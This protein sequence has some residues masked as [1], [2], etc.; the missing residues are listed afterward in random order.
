MNPLL[1]PGVGARL[2]RPR[3][4]ALALVAAA[5]FVATWLYRF[6]DPSG[7]FAGLT[8]DHFFYL[9]RGWQMLFGELPVRDFVDHGAPLYYYVAA[10]VQLVFGRGTLTELTFSVTVLA[11]STAIVFLLAVRASGSILLGVAAGVLM[12][13]LDPRFYNYPKILVYALA[14]PALWAF[15]DR[16]GARTRAFVAIVAVVG[17][18]FRHDH[19]VFVGLAFLTML[20]VLRSLPWRERLR[21]G[22]VTLALAAALLSPYLLFIQMN[23]GLASYVEQS[24]AWAE[25]DRDRA[26][27]VWPGFFDNPD[28]VSEETAQTT[29]VSHALAVLAD[30][31]VAWLYYAEIALPFV[32]LL[33]LALSPGAFRPEWPHAPAKLVT[34]AVL[35]VVLNAGFLRHP[36]E[37][38]LA[39]TFVPHAILIAW[40]AMALGRLLLRRGMLRPRLAVPSRAIVVKVLAAAVAVPL[41]A[42]IVLT[43]MRDWHRRLDKAA[44]VEGWDHAIE[45]VGH[46]RTSLGETWPLERWAKPEGTMAL[47][48]YFTAC[49]K[50]TDRVFMEHYLPQVLAL[51]RRGFA[52]GHADLRPGFF[53]SED[54]QR[55]TVERLRRQSVPVALLGPGE[56]LGGFRSSFPIIVAYLDQYYMSAGER[57]ID[58]RDPVQLF[59]RRDGVPTGRYEPLDWPCFS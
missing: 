35:A 53:T 52:G 41:L 14:I 18:L 51:S 25:R 20:L 2:V 29:G 27:V 24:A 22:V 26:E 9:V 23:G 8:D 56:D 48:F 32:A 55:L 43:S 45:R 15:A 31:W 49:T 38:R 54:M 39:D 46:I 1:P 37:A 4:G 21:H 42:V 6:N 3:T 47:A 33:M 10:A 59:V 28:G 58:G 30:N 44:M 5:V 19:G 50:P 17:F 36:I 34:V 12:M 7:S 16:P 13:F 11:A 40:L 57:T